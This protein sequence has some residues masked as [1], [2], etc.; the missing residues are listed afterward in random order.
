MTGAALSGTASSYF[1]VW[2]LLPPALIL[3]ALC[4]SSVAPTPKSLP[5]DQAASLSLQQKM[6]SP[7]LGPM[8]ESTHETTERRNFESRQ[9]QPWKGEH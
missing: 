3:L 7:K 6:D 8:M 4:L 9:R 5:T 1:G 2:V